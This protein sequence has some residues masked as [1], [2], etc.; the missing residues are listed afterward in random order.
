MRFFEAGKLNYSMMSMRIFTV[1]IF[2]LLVSCKESGVQIAKPSTFVRYFN[3]GFND[4][5]QTIIE[6]SDKGFLI[7]ANTLTNTTLSNTYYKIK[8]IKT[9][10]YGNQVWEHFYPDFGEV[11]T[12]GKVPSFEGF[13]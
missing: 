13:D 10:A 12:N 6:T 1:L 4:Q 8:L 5:A 2:L 7:L 11:D 9:D 3:G